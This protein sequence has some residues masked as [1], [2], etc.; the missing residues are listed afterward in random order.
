MQPIRRGGTTEKEG[1][2]AIHGRRSAMRLWA[3]VLLLALIGVSGVG[4]TLAQPLGD[5]ANVVVTVI[6]GA[7]GTT[8]NLH[9]ALSGTFPGDPYAV[10]LDQPGDLQPGMTNTY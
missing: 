7:N 8:G 2:A 9:L 6:T 4:G 10:P 1:L 5:S 3:A